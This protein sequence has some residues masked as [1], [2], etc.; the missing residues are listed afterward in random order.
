M[1]QTRSR[2]AHLR[3]DAQSSLIELIPTIG[4]QRAGEVAKQRI[5][6]GNGIHGQLQG[7]A[8]AQ[9]KRD[10]SRNRPVARGRRL[11]TERAP[12][13][14]GALSLSTRIRFEARRNSML[15]RVGRLDQRMLARTNVRSRRKET[16]RGW[17]G[18][19]AFGPTSDIR[20]ANGYQQFSLA[21]AWAGLVQRTQKSRLE[22]PTCPL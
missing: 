2:A 18:G 10:A 13:P 12:S 4:G 5:D 19:D 17:L 3:Q 15:R 6:I 1:R 9:A 8:H 16:W 22:P 20:G 14:R 21:V 7:L 11:Q